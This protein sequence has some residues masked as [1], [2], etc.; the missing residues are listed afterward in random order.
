M[1][2]FSLVLWTGPANT[3]LDAPRGTCDRYKPIGKRDT[4]ALTTVY[5]SNTWG[6]RNIALPWFW[7][8]AMADDSANST[9]LEEGQI[10]SLQRAGIKLRQT[11]SISGELAEGQKFGMTKGQKSIP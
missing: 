3:K 5:D 7:N 6:Q 11:N 9:Y 4:R 10:Q 1:V 2:R 8:M